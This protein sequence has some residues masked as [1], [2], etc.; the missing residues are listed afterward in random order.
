MLA[1]QAK[2]SLQISGLPEDPKKDITYPVPSRVNA[3]ID[4]IFAAL[5]QPHSHSISHLIYVVSGL[6]SFRCPL[7][8]AFIIIFVFLFLFLFFYLCS[9]PL[10][11]FQVQNATALAL[12]LTPVWTLSYVLC[13]RICE[14]IRGLLNSISPNIRLC[15][16]QAALFHTLQQW[17]RP[18]YCHYGM[19]MK[20]V[21]NV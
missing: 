7:S 2:I 8:F 17:N 19:K 9:S 20:A 18:D 13:C 12:L 3:I 21:Q 5:Y 1:S 15:Y 6:P 10:L 11:G 16:V 4:W 14:A